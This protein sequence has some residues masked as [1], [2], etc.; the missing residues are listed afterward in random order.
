M[1][2]PPAPTATVRGVFSPAPPPDAAEA[3]KG[4]GGQQDRQA[5]RFRNIDR[6]EQPVRFAVNPIGEVERVRRAVE[7]TASEI[8]G[9]QPAR[10]VAGPD[11][12]RD[13]AEK[14]PARRVKG[15]DLAV[16]VTE[17]ADQQIAREFAESGRGEGDAPRR[18]ELAADDQVLDEMAV[19][20]E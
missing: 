14:G 9:P 7:R 11:G 19:F 1:R 20:V 12:D 5:G 4:E 10:R 15:I 17:V 16:V 6:A 8:E 2:T 13:R 3:E 18:R